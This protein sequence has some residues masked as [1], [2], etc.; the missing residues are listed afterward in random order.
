MILD[1][2]LAYRALLMR[3]RQGLV[4][5]VPHGDPKGPTRPPAFYD[6][7]YSFLVSCGIPEI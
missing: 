6:E 5:F 4:V 2:M 3:A 7:T 1:N